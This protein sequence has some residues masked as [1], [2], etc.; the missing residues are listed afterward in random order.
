MS[1]FPIPTFEGGFEKLSQI[2]QEESLR[3]LKLLLGNEYFV[4]NKSK[5]IRNAKGFIY[6]K[7][8]SMTELLTNIDDLYPGIEIEES[9]LH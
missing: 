4:K 6:L 5:L 2:V 7:K 8:I 9:Y 1:S 3:E